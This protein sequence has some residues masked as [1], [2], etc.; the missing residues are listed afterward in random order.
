[1]KIRSLKIVLMVLMAL[2]LI[3]MLSVFLQLQIATVKTIQVVLFIVDFVILGG[4]WLMNHRKIVAP[5]QKLSTAAEEMSQTI[6]DIARNASAAT[7][8]S[9]EAM[10]TANSG[11][12][13]AEGAVNTVNKVYDSTLELAAMVEKLNKRASEI[14]DIATVSGPDQPPGP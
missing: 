11:N 13:I 14:G 7:E 5:L 6:T 1:M 3:S 9:E 2:S 8:K 10:K 12:E 4:L